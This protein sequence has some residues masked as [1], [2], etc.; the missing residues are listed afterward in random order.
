MSPSKMW[1]WFWERS[2]R[3]TE[4]ENEI[5]LSFEHEGKGKHKGRRKIGFIDLVIG[6]KMILSLNGLYFLKIYGLSTEGTWGKTKNPFLCGDFRIS[7]AL[8]NMTSTA[9]HFRWL[10]ENNLELIEVLIVVKNS[11]VDEILLYFLTDKLAYC[12]FR[13]DSRKPVKL[14]L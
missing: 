12:T 7:E 2:G 9:L 1:R 5:I 4:R 11:E 3:G 6:S 14:G 13:D 10:V 8:T